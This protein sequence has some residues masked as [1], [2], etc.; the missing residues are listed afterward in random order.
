[1][2]TARTGAVWLAVSGCAGTVAS[3]SVD[4]TDV[5]DTADVTDIVDAIRRRLARGS[6]PSGA[7]QAARE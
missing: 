4:A 3:V 5:T 2:S 7:A 1:M 6:P